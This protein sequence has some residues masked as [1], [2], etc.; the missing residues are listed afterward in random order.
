MS[1]MV[2]RF[3]ICTIARIYIR[4]NEFSSVIAIN[5]EASQLSYTRVCLSFSVFSGVIG[6]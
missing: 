5:G 3:H 2:L 1:S 6:L 4:L